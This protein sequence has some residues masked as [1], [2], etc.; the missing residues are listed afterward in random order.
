MGRGADRVLAVVVVAVLVLGV[1]VAW[2][3]TRREPVQFEVG[4]P[5]STVQQYVTAVVDRDVEGTGSLVVDGA[6]TLGD[7]TRVTV[8]GSVRVV[9]AGTTVRDDEASARLEVTQGS[10]GIL[11]DGW[12]SE[13][14][15]HL[16]R[17]GGDWRVTPDSWPLYGCDGW[18]DR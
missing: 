9:L 8:P 3:A 1:L 13:E 6:C 16:V 5:E 18:W 2:A 17:E 7:L 10:Q 12:T 11:G 14:V 15:V 4:S